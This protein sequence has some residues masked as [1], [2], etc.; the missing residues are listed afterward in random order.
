MFLGARLF[1]LSGWVARASFEEAYKVG[2]RFWPMLSM[3]I[4]EVIS[5][6]KTKEIVLAQAKEAA[7]Q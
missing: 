6:E 3:E 4:Q 1:G 7:G 5:W 2:N